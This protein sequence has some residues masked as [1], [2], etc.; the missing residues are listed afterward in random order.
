MNNQTDISLNFKN[1]VTNLKRLEE[2]ESRLKSIKNVVSKMPKGVKLAD[3]GS[4]KDY[5]SQLA[6]IE[7][8]LTNIN[9]KSKDTVKNL[10]SA[11]KFGKLTMF[12]IALRK[13]TEVIGKLTDKSSS[14]LE[15]L[16]L[17]QVAFNGATEEAD[18]FIDKLSDMYGLDEAWLVRTIGLFK[19]L[20]NAMRLTEEQGTKVS[21]LLTQMSIDI[22]SLYNAQPDRASQVLQSAMASQTRP[23]RGLSG[24]DITM[25]TLQ[26]TLNSLGIDRAINQL[27]FAEKRLIIIVSLTQQLNRVAND[28]G[29]TL[30]SP[31]NQTRILSEQWERLTRALGNVLLPIMSKIL[32]YL[33]GILMALVEIF[34]TIASLFGFKEEDY[35]FG[36]GI[37]D[38]ILDIEDELNSATESSEKLKNSLRGFDKLNNITTSTSTGTN[39]NL[40]ISPEIWDAFA[41]AYE[42]Y[43]SKIEEVRMKAHDIRDTLLQWYQK[44]IPVRRIIQVLNNIIN[45]VK[46]TIQNI[47]KTISDWVKSPQGQKFIENFRRTMEITLDIIDK[48]SSAINEIINEYL[49]P[50]LPPILNIISEIY[51]FLTKIYDYLKPIIDFIIDLIKLDLEI[52]LTGIKVA[53]EGISTALQIIGEIFSGTIDTISK[54]INGDFQGAYETWKT[55]W[56]KVEEIVGTVLSGIWNYLSEKLGGIITLIKDKAIEIINWLFDFPTRL[57]NWAGELYLFLKDKIENTDWGELGKKILNGIVDKI[58]MNWEKAKEIISSFWNWFKEAINNIDWG[59]LGRSILDG[60][61]AGISFTTYIME[62]ISEKFVNGFKKALGIN[63]PSKLMIDAKIGNYTFDGIMEGFSNEMPTLKEQ[64]K[65]IVSTLRDGINQ[66]TD[67]SLSYDTSDLAKMS[68]INVDKNFISNGSLNL[69]SKSIV[70]LSPTFIIQVGDEE[71]ARHTI[72]KMEEMAKANGKPFT[73]GG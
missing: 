12:Y 54:L 9:V 33:N 49:L 39:T 37:T 8:A 18:K 25:S 55:T 16:N 45:R 57:G 31:A 67:V 17:Y 10:S 13:I 56:A 61:L 73:I 50:L 21:M 48:I 62:K 3:I 71:L 40:G 6:N 24:A 70:N 64:A 26:T 52:K 32:P 46:T 65:E 42:E 51:D 23:I 59:K 43:M 41:K 34:N 69:D 2:Y 20:T 28:W 68:D 27:S 30:E 44:L 35:D 29:K 4:T 19:Q 63:S 1:S 58:K 15:S 53:L 22:S 11:F 36:V 38:E 72:N 47:V 14:Y 66:A 60:I 7:K 5:S